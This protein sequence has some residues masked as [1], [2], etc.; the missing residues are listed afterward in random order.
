MWVSSFL[1]QYHGSLNLFWWPHGYGSLSSMVR[2][3]LFGIINQQL[4]L[5]KPSKAL[6]HYTEN[7]KVSGSISTIDSLMFYYQLLEGMLERVVVN[8]YDIL[9][10][11]GSGRFFL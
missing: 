6:P 10:A 5:L 11:M 4:I 3:V 7:H 8:G 9:L 1:S 2:F